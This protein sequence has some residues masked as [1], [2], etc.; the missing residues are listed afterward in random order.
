MIARIEARISSIEGSCARCAR[1]N[2]SAS[3]LLDAA[4]LIPILHPPRRAAPA[5]APNR[6][7]FDLEACA[8]PR[9]CA[10]PASAPV[11]RANAELFGL[12]HVEMHARIV[13][14]DGKAKGLYR[15]AADVGEQRIGIDDLVVLGA[16][17]RQTR[18]DQLLLLVE[19]VQRRALANL[20]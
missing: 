3:S 10:S 8:R 13:F 18:V 7:A 4:T 5:A 14:G 12:D 19:H 17:Q 15:Q 6:R 9:A 16:D 2:A 1:R 20:G 11:R